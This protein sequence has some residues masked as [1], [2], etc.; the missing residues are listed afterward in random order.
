MS[1]FVVCGPPASG[2]STY[3]LE[4]AKSS[5]VVI[6]FDV[7]ARALGSSVSHGHSSAHAVVAN[8]ARSAALEAALRAGV[9]VWLIHAMPSAQVRAIYKRQGAELIVVDPG[10]AVVRERVARER[11]GVGSEYVDSWYRLWG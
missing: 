2:K 4:R 11:N 10:E 9:D 8:A 5:D 7:L 3:V 6:D 1:F